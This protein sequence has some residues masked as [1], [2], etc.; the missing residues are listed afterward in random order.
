L[1]DSAKFLADTVVTD[2]NWASEVARYASE[3]WQTAVWGCHTLL[4][5][6]AQYGVT[7]AVVAV[8]Y[9]SYRLQKGVACDRRKQREQQEKAA[10]TILAV[11]LDYMEAILRQREDVGVDD[12][13]NWP[14]LCVSSW[15]ANLPVVLPK[16]STDR[17]QYLTM[18]YKQLVELDHLARTFVNIRSAERKRAHSK[19]TRVAETMQNRVAA[20]R[21]DS[22]R[23]GELRRWIRVFALGD[24]WRETEIIRSTGP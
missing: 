4:Q 15:Q 21:N 17:A 8:A 18:I 9:F 16:L 20:Y 5:W 2:V 24:E 23:R 14:F 11:E 12:L 13:A 22:E 6:L 10:A 3:V 1:I 19:S 7:V